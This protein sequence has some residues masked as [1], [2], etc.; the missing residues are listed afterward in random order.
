M[1]DEL[2]VA[3]AGEVQQ[4]EFAARPARPSGP[5]DEPA[6]PS[7]TRSTNLELALQAALAAHADAAFDGAVIVSDGQAQQGDSQAG[8]QAARAAG[9]PLQWLAIA[10][11]PPPAHLAQVLAPGES[12]AGAMIRLSVQI[13]GPEAGRQEPR[14]Q[15]EATARSTGGD[16]RRA[17]T[18][19]DADGLATLDIEAPVQS[20]RPAALPRPRR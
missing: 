17:S 2:R 19:V 8:L 3:G 10:R 15:V 18:E 16:L 11:P 13:A 12:P 14:W 7:D 6:K 5:G 20:A 9:L 4:I 1:Q